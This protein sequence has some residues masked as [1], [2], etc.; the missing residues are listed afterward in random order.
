MAEPG[1]AAWVVPVDPEQSNWPA[2]SSRLMPDGKMA[3]N[4]LYQMLPPLS[5]DVAVQVSK[6]LPRD[7]S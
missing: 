5:E 2:V 4:P 7:H 3:S 6:Y 1:P